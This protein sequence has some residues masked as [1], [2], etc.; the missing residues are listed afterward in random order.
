M[1]NFY[2]K[3]YQKYKLKYLNLLN[4]SGGIMPQSEAYYLAKQYIKDNYEKLISEQMKI[5]GYYWNENSKEYTYQDS[6]EISTNQQ[7]QILKKEKEGYYWNEEYGEYT[8]FND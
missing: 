7:N 2:Q 6:I 1:S 5:Y 4:Q 3:K 8:R